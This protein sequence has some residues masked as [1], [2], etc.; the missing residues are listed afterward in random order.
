M[1]GC[2]VQMAPLAGS[3][4]R[5][6]V[7]SSHLNTA[8]WLGLLGALSAGP[9]ELHVIAAHHQ[10]LCARP[11]SNV[12][13]ITRKTSNSKEDSFSIVKL[14]IDCICCQVIALAEQ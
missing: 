12:R 3:P 14:E 5:L 7:R 8:A 1:L 4:L 2:A 11:E 10:W 9:L 6:K 13:E